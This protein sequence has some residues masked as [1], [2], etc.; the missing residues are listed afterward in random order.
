[1]AVSRVSPPKDA[2]R[3]AYKGESGEFPAA[4]DNNRVQERLR[5]YRREGVRTVFLLGNHE[6][7]LLRILDG[8]SSL[9]ASWLR[10]GGAECLASYGVDQ[11]KLT[12]LSDSQI[13]RKVRGAVPPEH[14]EFL[15][16][17]V[18]TC[19]LGDYLFV[20]AGIRPGVEL[21]DQARA[22]GEDV[23]GTRLAVGLRTWF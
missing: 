4:P 15:K 17:F 13:I 10:F 16:S 20:H 14:V 9:I 6:E 5:T 12:G 22:A 2:P 19:R 21:H 3:L 1:M 18:D 11:R 7:V 23:A 8:D